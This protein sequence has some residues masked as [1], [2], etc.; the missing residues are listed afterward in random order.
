MTDLPPLYVVCDADVCAGAGW[1]LADFAR[2]CLDGGARLLQIRAKSWSGQALLDVAAEV[3]DAARPAGAHVIVN[4]RAD[5]ALASGAWGV[6]V[7][8]LDLPPRAVRTVA[9]DR[10]IVGLSTHSDAELEAALGT[11]ADYLAI[12]PIFGTSTKDT[13]VPARGLEVLRASAGRA[14]QRQRPV[15]AIGGITL[16]RAA[17]VIDAGAQ[18]VAVISDLLATGRPAERVRAY[19]TALEPRR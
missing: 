19:L 16:A 11:P 6:H 5:V 4:D 14:R 15:V 12:G 3:V 8:Q 9:G 10:L 18:S 13:G 7:G 17:A 2:A 1:R